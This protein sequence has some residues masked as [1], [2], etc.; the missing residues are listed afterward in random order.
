[1]KTRL[2][3]GC[4]ACGEPTLDATIES[5]AHDH[6]QLDVILTCNADDGGCGHVRNGFMPLGDMLVLNA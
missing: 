3:A 1:M 6:A 2:E 5:A 4:P